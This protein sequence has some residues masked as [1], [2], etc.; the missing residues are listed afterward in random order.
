MGLVNP[1]E[2]NRVKLRF[3]ISVISKVEQEFYGSGLVL[4]KNEEKT[5][6]F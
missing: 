1:S 3:E 5:M 4:E 6:I 2:R